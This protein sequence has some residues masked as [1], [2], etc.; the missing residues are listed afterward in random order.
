MP[1]DH[2]R[3]NPRLYKNFILKKLIVTVKKP[4]DLER[5]LTDCTPVLLTVIVLTTK[6]LKVWS[7]I[8]QTKLPLLF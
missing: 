7:G 6:A 3:K 1:F 4:S 2:K 8:I 5:L